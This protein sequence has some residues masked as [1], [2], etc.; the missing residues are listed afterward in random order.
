MGKALLS[1]EW[2]KEYGEHWNNTPATRE[3]TSDLTMT[4][5]Y[6]LAEDHD[7]VGEIEVKDGEVV[8]AGSPQE[9]KKPDFLLTAKL[10]TWKELA[11]GKVGAKKAI[12]L[13]KLKFQGPLMVA[14]SHIGALEE[15]MRIFGRVSD[16]EWTA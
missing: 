8:Y 15:A 11:E 13:Q 2:I 7:R 1:P 3:G 6:R 12:T 10:D 14:L 5:H 16:T 9:G 4:I